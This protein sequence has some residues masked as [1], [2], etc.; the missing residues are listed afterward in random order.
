M[1][2]I[3]WYFVREVEHLQRTAYQVFRNVILS[4][5]LL[6]LYLWPLNVFL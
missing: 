3:Y 2:L 4:S 6:L 5:V 1:E